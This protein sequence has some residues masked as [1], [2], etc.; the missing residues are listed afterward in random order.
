M[1]KYIPVTRTIPSK[2]GYWDTLLVEIYQDGNKIGEYTRNYSYM[3]NTFCPFQQNGKDYALYSTDY[4]ATRVMEL[5]SCKDIAGEDGC[6]FGFCPTGYYVP[7]ADPELLG[8]DFGDGPII[9]PDGQFGFVCG[10]I[11]GD[12]RSWKIQYLDLTKISEG[13]LI[14]D[15]RFGYIELLGDSHKLPEAIHVEEFTQ[16]E[17]DAGKVYVDIACMKTFTIKKE[18]ETDDK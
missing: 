13:I 8:K 14:R 5:P 3:L 1:N 4:T 17:F 15:D 7:K 9:G 10:C 11:W 16:E 12:D 2:P 18:Q 6:G